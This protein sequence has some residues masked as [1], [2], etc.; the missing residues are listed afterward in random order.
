MGYCE[1]GFGKESTLIPRYILRR[2][3]SGKKQKLRI[4]KLIPLKLS[5]TELLFGKSSCTPV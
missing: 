5:K 4:R 2:M 1:W 3:N